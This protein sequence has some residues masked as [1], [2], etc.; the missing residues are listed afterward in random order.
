MRNALRGVRCGTERH[1]GRALRRRSP[2]RAA[3][4]RRNVVSVGTRANRCALAATCSSGPCWPRSWAFWRARRRPCSSSAWS[5]PP[6]PA[7]NALAAVPAAGGRAVSSACSTT[8]SARGARAATTCCSTKSTSRRR[9]ALAHGP[10]ILLSTV[11]THL[12][13]GSAGREGTAVQMGGSLAAWL[14]T[15]RCD[16]T[17]SHTRILLMAG[18][19]AGFRRGVRNAAGRH[20]V[21][22]GGAGRRPAPLRRA[23]SLPGGR[24]G[25]RLDVYGL[26]RAS[27][28]LRRPQ[29]AGADAPC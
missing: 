9:R 22:P 12:F 23:D 20:G 16:W 25:R 6:T 7:R 21:R 24:P 4:G 14:G 2:T 10:A 17:G 28:A 29:R 3:I 8:T 5:G 19:S 26:G 27:H 15:A 18:I 13:G 11:A 1:G